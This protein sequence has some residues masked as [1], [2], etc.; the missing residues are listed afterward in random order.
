MGDVVKA[1]HPALVA[2]TVALSPLISP[3]WLLICLWLWS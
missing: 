1:P 3:L 2:L